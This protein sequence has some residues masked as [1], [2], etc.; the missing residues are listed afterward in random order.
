MKFGWLMWLS[1]SGLMLN[2]C[3][4]QP[5]PEAT[6]FQRIGGLPMLT[7]ISS[8]LIDATANDERTKRSFKDVKLSVVKESLTNFLCVNAGGDCVYEGETMKKSHAD[9]NITT[10]EFKLMVQ[11]LRDI[12]DAHQIGA[13]EKNELLK[14]LAPTKRDIVTSNPPELKPEPN[15]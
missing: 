3:V 12:L 4:L 2:A 7:T 10:A 5:K 11:K 13:R 9:A 8:E 15:H 1:L 14:L 6:L